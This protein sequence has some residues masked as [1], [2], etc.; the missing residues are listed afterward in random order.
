MDRGETESVS[1]RDRLGASDAARAAMRAAKGHHL[2]VGLVGSELGQRTNCVSGQGV[3]DVCPLTRKLQRALL[4]LGALLGLGQE[5]QWVGQQSV[6]NICL[7][8]TAASDLS[9]TMRHG[10]PSASAAWRPHAGH[11]R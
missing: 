9:I 5:G 11:R 1:C 3:D 10:T 2:L 4:D 6:A 8:A 7:S